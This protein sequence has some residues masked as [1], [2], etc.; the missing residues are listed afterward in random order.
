[1]VYNRGSIGGC[2]NECIPLHTAAYRCIPLPGVTIEESWGVEGLD[3]ID[4]VI[5]LPPL[6]KKS[7]STHPIKTCGLMSILI[8][9]KRLRANMK[10]RHIPLSS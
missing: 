1:M 2:T 10:N 5:S 9:G 7:K 6:Q 4:K 8:K 3:T